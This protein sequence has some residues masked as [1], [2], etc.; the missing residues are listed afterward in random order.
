M[1][2][3]KKAREPIVAG[4]RFDT[5]YDRRLFPSE[6]VSELTLR[7]LK[8]NGDEATKALSVKN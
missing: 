1:C 7:C 3:L 2:V 5:V 4:A 8:G 6:V